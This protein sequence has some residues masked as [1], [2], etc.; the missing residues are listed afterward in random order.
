L[1]IKLMQRI[2]KWSK[3]MPLSSLSFKS[4]KKT[5]KFFSRNFW[6]KRNKTQFWRPKFNSMKNCWMKSVKKW[7]NRNSKKNLL[8]AINNCRCLPLGPNCLRSMRWKS[9]QRTI[10]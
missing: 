4:R 5:K 6:W 3:S 10:F 7:N 1:H 2:S 9:R 8:L